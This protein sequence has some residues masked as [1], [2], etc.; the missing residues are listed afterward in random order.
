MPYC[1]TKAELVAPPTQPTEVEAH[2]Y[3]A[4]IQQP[5]PARHCQTLHDGSAAQQAA[6]HASAES[7]WVASRPKHWTSF[8]GKGNAHS[9]AEGVAVEERER[10]ELAVRERVVDVTPAA[11]CA[12]AIAPGQ[13]ERGCIR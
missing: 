11:T 8:L 3:G 9:E 7:A 6:R 10:V 1:G 13:N 5:S 2:E 4:P 12:T